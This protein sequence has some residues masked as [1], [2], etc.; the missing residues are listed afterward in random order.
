MII[1]ID[2]PSGTGKS[3]V[4]KKVAERLHFAYFD[5]GAMYRALTW[6]LIHHSVDLKNQEH[7]EQLLSSFH[8]SIEEKVVQGVREK[9]YYVGREDVTEVIRSR[10]VTSHVSEVS[11][12]KFVRHALFRVQQ[13]FAQRKDVVV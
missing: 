13:E 4:A 6:Y 12:L 8:F 11:A 9:R 1:T 10:L 7:I 5:T 3:T 2:G